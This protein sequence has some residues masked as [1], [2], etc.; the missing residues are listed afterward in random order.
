MIENHNF[1]C[2]LSL[3]G[4]KWHVTTVTLL[5]IMYCRR[6]RVS[7]SDSHTLVLTNEWWDFEKNEFHPKFAYLAKERNGPKLTFK[8][9]Y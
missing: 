7:H 2:F 8:L 6:S 4:S 3:N 5:M 9:V 1:G